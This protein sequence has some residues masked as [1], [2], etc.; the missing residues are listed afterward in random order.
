M[1]I[2]IIASITCSLSTV[3]DDG[4]ITY[5]AGVVA[6]GV[7]V[8]APLLY[9]TIKMFQLLKHVLQNAV[10]YLCCHIFHGINTRQGEYQD[11]SV[12]EIN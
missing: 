6:A 1:I 4:Q 2:L 12:A 3:T 10:V 11:L 5:K 7:V 8:L 9:F